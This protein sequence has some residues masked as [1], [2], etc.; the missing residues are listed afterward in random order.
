MSYYISVL[1]SIY[2]KLAWIKCACNRVNDI[3]TP[4]HA[5]QLPPQ[6]DCWPH[7]KGFP[8]FALNVNKHATLVF[9]EHRIAM[10]TSIT[11]KK[12]KCRIYEYL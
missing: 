6:F 2:M 8:R 4:S 10:A 3:T 5:V 11:K 9:Q 1:W 12:K 7:Y